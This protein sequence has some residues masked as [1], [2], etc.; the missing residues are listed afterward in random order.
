M[1]PSTK[2]FARKILTSISGRA[3]WEAVLWIGAKLAQD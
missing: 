1:K 2:Q 3:L